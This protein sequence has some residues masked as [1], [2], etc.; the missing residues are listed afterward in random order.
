MFYTKKPILKNFGIFTGKHLCSNLFLNNFAGLRPST[1]LKKRFQ[2][3]YFHVNISKNT[4]EHLLKNI[5][6]RLLLRVPCWNFA[7]TQIFMNKN[8]Y[9]LL[10]AKSF[11][12][13]TLEI[14]VLYWVS[15]CKLLKISLPTIQLWGEI[16]INFLTSDHLR[17]FKTLVLRSIFPFCSICQLF[18]RIFCYIAACHS[19]TLHTASKWNDR[20]NKQK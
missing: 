11:N 15:I 16:F 13:V 18:Y 20:L 19:V 5:Y 9:I 10:N 3:R 4:C 12:F 8:K 1:L 17:I 14:Q 7:T 2:H 6:E